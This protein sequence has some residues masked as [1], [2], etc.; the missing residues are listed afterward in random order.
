MED[1]SESDPR[2]VN[3]AKHNLN[4]IR[5]DG[6]IGC[7]VNGAGL[8]MATMDVI[9]LH[10]ASPANFLDVG[11]SVNENQVLEAFKLVTSDP[12]VKAVLVNIFGGI[13]DCA[14]IATGVTKAAK[15]VGL[16]IPL[17]VRVQGTNVKAAQQILRESGLPIGTA[18]SLAEAAT[19]AVHSIA[20]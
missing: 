17:V 13:V 14:T 8:A 4:Y 19:K 16:A 7:L 6:S 2:E 3:A 18:G 5:M 20:S 12:Q 10:G 15:Q 11:G 1:V 9:K